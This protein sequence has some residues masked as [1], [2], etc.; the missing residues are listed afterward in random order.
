VVIATSSTPRAY[1]PRGVFY[2]PTERFMDAFNICYGE[3]IDVYGRSAESKGLVFV[4]ARIRLSGTMCSL[5]LYFEKHE[6]F[7]RVY[8]PELAD[9]AFVRARIPSIF[10]Y[11]PTYDDECEKSLLSD[12]FVVV[13]GDGKTAI[14]FECTDYYGRTAL[15]FSADGPDDDVKQQIA[16]AFWDII[17]SRPDALDDFEQSVFHPGACVWLHYGCKRGEL[18]CDE[19]DEP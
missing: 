18:F 14:P 7:P 4:P 5:E 9:A 6:K 11:T 17:A 8:I 12:G 1:T 2:A 10:G 15:M 16:D 13:L 3:L 19:S